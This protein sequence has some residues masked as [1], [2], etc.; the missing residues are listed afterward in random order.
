MQDEGETFDQPSH[1]SVLPSPSALSECRRGQTSQKSVRAGSPSF[2]GPHTVD[3]V[4]PT[5]DNLDRSSC[6]PIRYF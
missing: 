2:P 6:P 5:V 1:S 4:A 3:S